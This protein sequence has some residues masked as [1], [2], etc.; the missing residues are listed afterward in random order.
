MISES[1]R[2]LVSSCSLLDS[3]KRKSIDFGSDVRR[4]SRSL[5]PASPAAAFSTHQNCHIDTNARHSTQE[6]DIYE[7]LSSEISCTLVGSNCE[8]SY[9]HTTCSHA[10]QRKSR[11]HNLCTRLSMLSRS[12]VESEIIVSS[13][14]RVVCMITL[15]SHQ[16]PAIERRSRYASTVKPASI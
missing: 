2:E 12:S 8:Y 13:A 15:R 9:T 4:T 11:R 6:G 7:E 3:A 10:G 1:V 16:A 14:I 5:E